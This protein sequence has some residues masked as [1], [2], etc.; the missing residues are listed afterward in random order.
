MCN[1]F[2]A[3]FKLDVKAGI[4]EVLEVST[5]FTFS[6]GTESTHSLQETDER[7]KTLSNTINVPPKKKVHVSIT[8]DRATFD[9]AYTGTV[10]ITC[11]NG[12]VL[13]YETKGQYK[14]V[15]YTEIKMNLICVEIV[16]AGKIR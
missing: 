13:Q 11:K 10:K 4:P 8:I 6:V 2:T 7:T 12:S 14:G 15:T 3:T 16:F 9:M 1:S 5:G